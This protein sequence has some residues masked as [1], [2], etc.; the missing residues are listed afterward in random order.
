[1]ELEEDN[2]QKQEKQAWIEVLV[3]I[4]KMVTKRI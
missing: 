1:M 3:K 2:H 4:N